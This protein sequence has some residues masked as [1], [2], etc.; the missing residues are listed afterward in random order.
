MGFTR[1]QDQRI[2]ELESALEA[3][4]KINNWRMHLSDEDE[5]IV[6]KAVSDE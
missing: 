2:K 4:M 6:E 3:L 5:V 1:E